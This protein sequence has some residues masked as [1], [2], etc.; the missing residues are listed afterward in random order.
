M[1][2]KNLIEHREKEEYIPESLLDSFEFGP[3]AGVSPFN[4]ICPL[5][6]AARGGGIKDLN[7]R[8]LLQPGSSGKSIVVKFGRQNPQSP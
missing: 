1:P 7:D 3:P 4:G 5:D 2:Q 6:G 8:V